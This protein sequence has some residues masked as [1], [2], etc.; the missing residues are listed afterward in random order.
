MELTHLRRIERLNLVLAGVLCAAS[1]V[2]WRRDVALGTALGA[3]LAV[4]NFWAIRRVTAHVLAGVSQR[5]Q[6]LLMS[7]LV[8]KMTALIGL[9]YVII[10]YA[11]VH[12]VA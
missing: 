7:L 2:F 10:R 9:V 5:K 8:A 3:G 12:V 1:L 11:P 4:V 6:L